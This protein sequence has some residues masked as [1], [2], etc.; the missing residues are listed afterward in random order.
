LTTLVTVT[1][2]AGDWFT[3]VAALS[4]AWPE[5]LPAMNWS[6]PACTVNRKA[7]CCSIRASAHSTA[8]TPPSKV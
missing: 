4:A 8:R 3:A 6:S 2:P 7:G 1:W 5:M